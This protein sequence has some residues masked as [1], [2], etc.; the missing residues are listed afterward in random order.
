MTIVL[1]KF[2]IIICIAW[3]LPEMKVVRGR[4]GR[5]CNQLFI[6]FLRKN[7][8]ERE[9]REEREREKKEAM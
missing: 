5:V 3:S 9:E 8:E 6:I 2:L 7:Q 1:F 4:I